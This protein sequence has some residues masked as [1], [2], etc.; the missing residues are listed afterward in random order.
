M[1]D[2]ELVTIFTKSV[3]EGDVERALVVC[4]YEGL[5]ELSCAGLTWAWEIKDGKFTETT[6]TPEGP[7]YSV[8]SPIH[9][10]PSQLAPPT[11]TQRPFTG[12]SHQET[13]SLTHWYQ[14]WTLC[15]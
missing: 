12:C 1:A 6:L 11:R 10:C 5:D 9:Y 13:T 4:S 15:R 2:R 14:S 3:L 7:T 8:S